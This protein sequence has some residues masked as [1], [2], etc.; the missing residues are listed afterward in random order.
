MKILKI[1][2]IFLFILILFSCEKD[3][4]MTNEVA[5]IPFGKSIDIEL[6]GNEKMTLEFTDLLEDSRCPPN[7]T[8]GWAGECSFTLLVNGKDKLKFGFPDD[9]YSAILEYGEYKITITDV[10][11]DKDDNFGME[12]HC[13]VKLKVE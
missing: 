7:V 2:T 8:C 11:Y 4:F 12:K 6:S 13:T 5:N 9:V 1:C 10:L 3:I